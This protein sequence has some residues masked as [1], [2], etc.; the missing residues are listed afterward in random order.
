M[1]T[2]GEALRREK[3]RQYGLIFDGVPSE[4]LLEESLRLLQWA[5]GTGSWKEARRRKSQPVGLSEE[6]LT[7][8]M[9]VARGQVMAS[10]RGRFPAPLAAIDAIAKGCNLPLKEALTVETDHFVPLVGI[11]VSPTMI[12][13]FFIN[14]RLQTH[15]GV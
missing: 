15:P 7:F 10:T 12:A 3:A 6:Q 2:T 5:R 11:P 8:A 14:Q 1:V 9:A 4:R 13:R